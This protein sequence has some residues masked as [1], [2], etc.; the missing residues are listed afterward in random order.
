MPIDKKEEIMRYQGVKVLRIIR[1]GRY[2]P[3]KYAW[4]KDFYTD[5]YAPEPRYIR[6]SL[7]GYIE[8]FI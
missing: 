2:N 1:F 3:A 5:M 6:A 7:I 8:V 4:I